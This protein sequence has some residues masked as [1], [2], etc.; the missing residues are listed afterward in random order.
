[1]KRLAPSGA[2]IHLRLP[3]NPES[4]AAARHSV[5]CLNNALGD[6]VMDDVRLL[7]SELVT[8]ALRHGR[9][10]PGDQIDLHVDVR[11]ERI[12][13]EV[14]DPGRGF[15]PEK[16]PA[17]RASSTPAELPLSGSGWG[18]VLVR[19]IASRWGVERTGGTCVWFELDLREAADARRTPRFAPRGHG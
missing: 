14:L 8:N 5:A 12:R 4:V 10:D 3:V 15:D 16:T 18:L 9:L 1:M 6:G 17:A 19:R 2:H 11:D 7:I 13:I